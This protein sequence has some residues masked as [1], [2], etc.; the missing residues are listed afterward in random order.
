MASLK[1]F[2]NKVKE[3]INMQEWAEAYKIVNQILTLDPENSTFIKYKFKI[4]K[5]VQKVNKKAINSELNKLNKLLNEQNYEEYLREIAP[6]Q[7]YINDFPIIGEKIINAKKLLDNQVI[8]RR[9]QAFEDLKKEISKTD[10]ENN[11]QNNLVKLEQL[12]KLNIKKNE[13]IQLQNNI[14]KSWVNNQIII[15]KGLLNSTKYEDS[16]LFL[17]KLQKIDKKN[18]KIEKLISKVKKEYQIQKIENK[19]D[20]IFKTIEEI[21]TLYITKKY[22]KCLELS[23][24]ILNIDPKNNIANSF[25]K[26]CDI[27]AKRKSEKEIYQQISIYY[28]NFPKSNNYLENN[29]IKL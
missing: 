20:F 28:K 1:D 17:L 19:K 15:N 23:E 24:A 18:K 16:L 21:K 5:E 13:V 3:H 7:A 6:L 10:I 11:Y 26:K 8:K 29:Y 12:A 9:N 25:Y 4:E 14:K 27:K 2:E 22:D